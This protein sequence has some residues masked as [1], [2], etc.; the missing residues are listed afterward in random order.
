MPIDNGGFVVAPHQ[1][2]NGGLRHPFALRADLMSYSP[3][4][5]PI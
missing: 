2:A 1:T 5:L 4:A 3:Y